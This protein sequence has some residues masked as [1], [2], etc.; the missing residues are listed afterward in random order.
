LGDSKESDRDPVCLKLPV[1]EPVDPF[2]TQ[3]D[4]LKAMGFTQS[5]DLIQCLLEQHRG[6]LQ[7]VV[8]AMCNG[9]N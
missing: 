8:F 1:A 3:K 4:Q 6:N 5:A 2:K 7:E 9:N